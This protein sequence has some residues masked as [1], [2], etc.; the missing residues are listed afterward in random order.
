MV[1]LNALQLRLKIIF[2][3]YDKSVR[4]IVETVASAQLLV[5]PITVGNFIR[6]YENIVNFD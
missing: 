6:G 3:G 4:N 1:I 5:A 2:I